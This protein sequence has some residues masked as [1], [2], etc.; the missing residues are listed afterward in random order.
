MFKKMLLLSLLVPFMAQAFKITNNSSSTITLSDFAYIIEAAEGYYEVKPGQTIEI[1]YVVEF[2]ALSA[3]YKFER[4]SY[5]DTF[6]Q[7][8][9]LENL[10]GIDYNISFSEI[11]KPNAKNG[12]KF[13]IHFNGKKPE[14]NNVCNCVLLEGTQHINILK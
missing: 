8:F 13:F 2:T 14:H 7:R 3:P 9:T 12:K 5:I 11:E 10:G 4:K 6:K 1:P